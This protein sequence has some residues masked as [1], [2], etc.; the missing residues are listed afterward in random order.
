VE[1]LDAVILGAGPAG[2][3]AGIGLARAGLAVALLEGAPFP[4]DRPG[5]TLHPGAEALFDQ[6]GVRAE[7]LAAGYLRHRGTWVEWGR[8]ATFVP[9]GADEA[10]PWLGFQAW[11]ADL[12]ARLLA[13]ARAAGVQVLQPCRAER[14][15]LSGGRV[16]GV[17]SSKGLIESSYLI[18]ASGGRHWLARRLRL[19]LERYSPPLRVRYGY[20]AG[21]CPARDDAPALV[22]D[23]EGWTWSA[24]V[25]PGLYQWTR[26][27]FAG[28]PGQGPP[29][30]LRPLAPVGPVRGAEVS[31]RRVTAPAGP[32][33]FLT[34][35]AAA[36]LDPT[37]SHGVLRALLSGA[38]A[39][40]LIGK[41]LAEGVPE[42]VAADAYARWLGEGVR[43]DVA[44]LW[45]LYAS[46]RHPPA[47]AR[48]GA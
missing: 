35:D 46:L 43:K 1:R 24:H 23:A 5:E 21:A 47:W 39:A 16:R 25:R 38:Q 6:L 3:A 32:G 12:D 19:P 4:R 18:D 7:V 26:L 20:R 42:A 40:Y 37:S 31:W 13:Q 15:L 10:G 27:T 2:C 17:V 30:E 14:P 8:E 33:Y 28:P 34:G 11:G 41:V 44:N 36:V 48:G 9:F 22:A 29:A 45:G